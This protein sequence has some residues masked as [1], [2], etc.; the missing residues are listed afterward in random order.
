MK[1]ICSLCLKDR[2]YRFVAKWEHGLQ[3]CSKCQ[4]VLIEISKY[5]IRERL[6]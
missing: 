5:T 6:V 2:D 3:L 1:R 4:D